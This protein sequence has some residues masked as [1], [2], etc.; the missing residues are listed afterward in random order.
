MTKIYQIFGQKVK[1]RRK[2]LGLTQEELAK[3]S[4]LHRTYIAGIEAGK[5]NISLKSLEKLAKALKVN[6]EDLLK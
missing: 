3:A 2:E 4:R 6:P 1:E 5:R